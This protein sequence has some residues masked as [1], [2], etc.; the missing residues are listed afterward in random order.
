MLYFSRHEAQAYLLKEFCREENIIDE[1][2]A[3]CF[4][5]YEMR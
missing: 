2:A 4:C 3:K 5:A 1:T